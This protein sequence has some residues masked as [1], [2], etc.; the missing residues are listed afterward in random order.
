MSD[1]PAFGLDKLVLSSNDPAAASAF[2]ARAGGFSFNRAEGTR[3][4]EAAIPGGL[5]LVIDA[6]SEPLLRGLRDC[7]L[8][9]RV[10]DLDAT[11]ARLRE[12][13]VE[14]GSFEEREGGRLVALKDP[15]GRGVELW[16]PRAA[17]LA[18]APPALEKPAIIEAPAVI[19]PPP[20]VAPPPVEP[21]AVVE[22]RPAPVEPPAIVDAKPADIEPPAV[23]ETKPAD[24]EPPPLVKMP[25]AEPAEPA[26]PVE[27]RASADAEKTADRPPEPPPP[28]AMVGAPSP[29]ISAVKPAVASA[30]GGTKIAVSGANFVEGCRVLVGGDPAP[31]ARFVDDTLIRLEAPARAAGSIDLIVENPDGKRATTR[32]VYDDGP[33]I[34]EFSPLDGPLTG[35]TEVIVEGRN[36]QE[37]CRVTFFGTKA[38]EV[39][40]MSHERLRFTTPPHEQHYHGEVRVTNPDGLSAVAAELF[41]YRLATPELHGASPVTGLVGGGKRIIVKGA[42]FHPQCVVRLGGAAAGV[43]WKG[44]DTLEVITPRVDAPGAVDIEIENPDG[45]YAT[46]PGAFTFEPAPTPPMLVDVQPARGYCAGGQVIR[47]FGDNFEEDT[48]VRVGEV[49]AVARLVSRREMDVELPPRKEAGLVA[50]ELTD[51]RGVV[52]RREDVFTY[53]ARPAPRVDEVTPRSGPT[54]GGTKLIIEGE[55]FDDHVYVRIGGLTP[56]QFVVRSGTRIEAIAPP[57]REAGLVD[58]E[59]GRGDAGLFVAKKAFRYDASPPPVIQSIAPNKGNVDGGTEISIEGKGFTAESAVLFGRARVEKVKFV[60]P[61]L[62][63]LKAPPGKNGEMVDITVRNPDGKEAV[64]KRAFMYDARYRG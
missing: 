39:V 51:R 7:A 25:P 43:T 63:E 41:T 23:V 33:S 31:T 49:R 34:E 21:P 55:Y 29:I 59:V 46:L 54:M 48:I 37:G 10:A 45:Q 26:P 13:G 3:R 5:T 52:V 30:H 47:L 11:A 44:R 14:V 35:G 58:V 20:L 12:L 28:P 1:T 16:E 9:L 19:E 27:P 53:E 15:D 57:S 24:I 6:A 38:P 56:K 32:L 60:S 42:D 61:T 17:A 22:A 36:F 40:L 64:S 2:Y 4:Y 18:E 62:L 8:T 50:I